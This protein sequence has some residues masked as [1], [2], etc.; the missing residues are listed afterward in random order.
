MRYAG[1]KDTGFLCELDVPFYA[2]LADIDAPASRLRIA[3]I[4][5]F[6]EVGAAAL[7]PISPGLS[8]DPEFYRDR[9]KRTFGDASARRSD[10]ELY[11]EWL[12]AG[13]R[14][15][16]GNLMIFTARRFGVE[17]TRDNIVPLDIYRLANEDL[18]GMDDENLISHALA[19][20]LFEQRSSIKITHQNI[21]VLTQYA[22]HLF[23]TGNAGRAE[24]LY[25]RLQHFVDDHPPLNEHF[26]NMLLN[27]HHCSRLFL[28]IS[29]TSPSGGLVLGVILMLPLVANGSTTWLAAWAYWTRGSVSTPMFSSF[30]ALATRRRTAS[31]KTSSRSPAQMRWRAGFLPR[32]RGSQPRPSAVRTLSRARLRLEQCERSRCLLTWTCCSARFTA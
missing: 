15:P 32:T 21:N 9:L 18:A 26:A 1:Y 6:V 5:H 20:G 17:C 4:F 11:R 12:E 29:E 3:C 22:D 28:T 14:R 24:A 13:E 2:A 19:D 10:T 23:Q 27:K 7:L 25:R 30:D 31:L 8:F 16:P